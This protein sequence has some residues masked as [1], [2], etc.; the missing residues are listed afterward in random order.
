MPCCVRRSDGLAPQQH[1]LQRR[2]YSFPQL[3]A[4]RGLVAS[5]FPAMPCP[6]QLLV[7]RRYCSAGRKGIE[8]RPQSLCQSMPARRRVGKAV[9]RISCQKRSV[10][11]LQLLR[12]HLA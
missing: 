10:R 7:G 9:L 2:L 5:R 4:R 11:C 8:C 6:R 3:R 12:R 1:L